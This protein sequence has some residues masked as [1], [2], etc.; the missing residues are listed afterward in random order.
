M[1]IIAFVL[2]IIFQLLIVTFFKASVYHDPF[3]VLYQAD[4]LSHHN[5]NWNDST[6]F[7]HCPNNIPLVYLLAQWFKFT[8]IFNLPTNWALNLLCIIT[9]DIFIALVVAIIKQVSGKWM[10]CL[11]VTIFFLITP[12][13]YSYLL[14][15]FYSDILLLISVCGIWLALVMWPNAVKVKKILFTVLIFLCG[16]LGM[17]TKP[18]IVVLIVSLGVTA[19]LFRKK[20]GLVLPTIALIVGISTAPILNQQ[21]VNEVH[22]SIETK[23]KLPVNTWIYMGLNNQTS[24]T[25]ARKDINRIE[26]LSEANRFKDTNKLIAQ[27]VRKLNPIGVVKQWVSK[28]EICENV[29]TVQGAYMS[30]NYC[31]PAWFVKWQPIVSVIVSVIFRSLIILIMLRIIKICVMNDATTSWLVLLTKLTILGFIAFYSIVWETECR[32]GL[33]LLPLYLILIAIP[34]HKRQAHCQKYHSAQIIFNGLIFGFLLLNLFTQNVSA[35]INN[36]SGV[37]T[38]QNSQ[39]SSYYKAKLTQLAPHTTISEQV[40]LTGQAN[41][42]SVI[43]PK[44][45]KVKVELIFPNNETKCLDKRNGYAYYHGTMKSGRYQIRI[46]N[47]TAQT[48]TCTVIAPSSYKL[49]KYPI[50]GDIKIKNGYLVYSF[51][52][53]RLK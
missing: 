35:N 5:F 18:S 3:R 2:L 12:L 21:I 36:F 42:F 49:A 28:I 10:S 13:A 44:N 33:I 40:Q 37:I 7:S 39:L 23:Y 43:V 11:K 6:Y 30:G 1:T 34:M 20:N 24:G 17:L 47:E 26:N 4:L 48:Q 16:L 29:G 22:F 52:N 9:V 32:Y 45:S 27:R 50:K 8:Q 25:Y 38:A 51:E 15:V 41:D 31:A 19:F 46:L 53:R 14:Q